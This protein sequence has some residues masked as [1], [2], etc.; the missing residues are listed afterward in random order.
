[1]NLW[2]SIARNDR[3]GGPTAIW[4]YE[5]SKSRFPES[6]RNPQQTPLQISTP[7][8]FGDGCVRNTIISASVPVS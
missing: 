3:D 2:D 8:A 1:M 4:Y 5:N 6:L 7:K